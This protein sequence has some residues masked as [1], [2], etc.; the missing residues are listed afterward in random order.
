M[1]LPENEPDLGRTR[2]VLVGARVFRT[3]AEAIAHIRGL[4]DKYGPGAPVTDSADEEF[5]LD[6]LAVH[7][8]ARE[9]IGPGVD[10]F[11]VR[12]NGPTI[13]FGIV[14]TDGSDTD[15]SFYSC[16]RAPSHDEEVRAAMREAIQDQT[17]GARDAAFANS[18]VVCPFTGEVLA[19]E[20]CHVHHEGRE[21]LEL[22][23][24]FADQVGGY[25]R[26][27]VVTADGVIGRRFGDEGQ[28]RRWQRFHSEN[29]QLVVVSARANLSDLRR[30]RARR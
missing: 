28:M 24:A 11:D 1:D 2:E 27:A 25:E 26:I 7:P 13:G 17:V 8:D 6:L 10:H 21:F 18:E 5:L 16:L 3:K 9:K 22:A 15:F 19:R 20:T 4:R 12:R 14:R 23:N 29:A 30:G